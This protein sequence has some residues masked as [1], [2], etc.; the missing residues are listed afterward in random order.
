MAAITADVAIVGGG[1][2]GLSTALALVQRDAALTITVLEKEP[3]FGRHQSGHNSGVI[4]SGVYYRPGSLKASLCAAGATE[5]VAFC[6]ENGVP[7]QICGKVIVATSEAEVRALDELYRRGDANGLIGLR[8]LDPREL[9]EIEPHAAGLSALHVP[10]TGVVDYRDVVAALVRRLGDQGVSMVTRAEVLRVRTA[11]SGVRL[12]TSAGQVTAA[13]LINCAGLYADV[14]A[15]RAGAHPDVQIVPVRGEYY[16]LRPERQDLVR[17]LI[18]PVPDPR[19]PFLGVHFTRTVHGAVEAGPN[20]V[21][22]FAREGYR[23]TTIRPAELLATLGYPGFHRMARRYWRTGVYEYYRSWSRRT[24]VNALQRLVPDLRMEDIAPGGAG[25]RAQAVGRD[26]RLVD[27]FHIVQGERAIH[28][29][30]APSPAATASLAIGRHI[31]GVAV[32]VLR[33]PG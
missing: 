6:T 26:G 17:G 15:R 32:E 33:R 21:M 30:N 22:A 11:G 16:H 2:V 12:T 3:A 23:K 13:L 27:D 7:F 24:F 18:Y 31:A 29:L 9:R 8:R 28:V 25:V 14:V 10:S 5:M 20:A 1:I 4:H 19:F